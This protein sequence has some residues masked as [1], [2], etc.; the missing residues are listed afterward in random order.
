MIN[1]IINLVVLITAIFNFITIVFLYKRD[2]EANF[3]RVISLAALL[4]ASGQASYIIHY[5]YKTLEPDIFLVAAQV[6][7]TI[8]IGMSRGSVKVA[9]KKTITHAIISDKVEPRKRPA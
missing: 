6:G 5:I 1:E 3:S 8:V 4:I 2:N 7:L 9:A